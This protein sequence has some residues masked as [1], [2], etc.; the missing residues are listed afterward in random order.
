METFVLEERY[1]EDIGG[2]LLHHI[3]IIQVINSGIILMDRNGNIL[4]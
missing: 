4:D 2:E 1:I 3:I